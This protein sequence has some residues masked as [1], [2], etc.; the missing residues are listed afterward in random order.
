MERG[1][2][3]EIEIYCTTGNMCVQKNKYFQY[4][5]KS[6]NCYPHCCYFDFDNKTLWEK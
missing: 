6:S 2:E 1:R 4:L 3:R 5:M